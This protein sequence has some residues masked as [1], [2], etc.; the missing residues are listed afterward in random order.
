[1]VVK[2]SSRTSE[3]IFCP[4]GNHGEDVK[5]L[6]YYL[7]NMPTHAYMKML[8]KYPQDK[9]PY[10]DL[11]HKNAARTVKDPE[12]EVLDTGRMSFCSKSIPTVGFQAGIGPELAKLVVRGD[13]V[14]WEILLSDMVD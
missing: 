9:Y 1:M 4:Q 10:S 2:V 12:Y 11:V 13:Y 14:D 5:E 6:Y 8:Y 7:D 3:L